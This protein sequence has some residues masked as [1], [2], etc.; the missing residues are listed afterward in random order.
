M[1]VS[2]VQ[3]RQVT[4]GAV[5]AGLIRTAVAQALARLEC[6]GCGAAL[7]FKGTKAPC[8]LCGRMAANGYMCTKHMKKK[9]DDDRRSKRRTY[10]RG[11]YRCGR[12]GLP[13]HNARTCE[14]RQSEG[15]V[16]PKAEVEAKA[17]AETN[18]NDPWTVAHAAAPELHQDAAAYAVETLRH[19]LPALASE[20]VP[21]THG[22]AAELVRN[23]LAWAD[24]HR[25]I[26]FDDDTGIWTRT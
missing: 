26:S 13:G 21:A 8:V 19:Q 7:R 9:W 6:S 24:G 15:K 4:H 1:P 12:C 17:K 5:I 23:A 18:A 14:G 16:A 2:E 25:L 3:L 20:L 22:G 11:G 10:E